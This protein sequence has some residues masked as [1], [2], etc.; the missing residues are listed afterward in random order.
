MFT[1]ILFLENLQYFYF[2]SFGDVRLHK[3]VI[4]V[5]IWTWF[6]LW[7]VWSICQR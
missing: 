3:S 6:N 5:T 7:A 1:I 2:L 4:S